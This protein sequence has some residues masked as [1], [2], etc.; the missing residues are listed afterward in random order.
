[1]TAPYGPLSATVPLSTS[2][3][4]PTT[5]SAGITSFNQLPIKAPAFKVALR[6]ARHHAHLMTSVED[7]PVHGGPEDETSILRELLQPAHAA[8]RVRPTRDDTNL[9]SLPVGARAR[10]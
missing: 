7:L 9:T 6:H 3:E 2:T 1:M 5:P 4:L 8:G 10:R